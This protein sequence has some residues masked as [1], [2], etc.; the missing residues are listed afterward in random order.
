MSSLVSLSNRVEH[1]AA[2]VRAYSASDGS[3]ALVAWID[4]AS[5]LYKQELVSVEPAG[6]AA[7]QA[8]VRQLEMLR[9]LALGALQT[10]G[11]I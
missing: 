11:C 6:L 9:L 3:G 1:A 7:L 2:V 8:Q 4:A 5:D 10:N